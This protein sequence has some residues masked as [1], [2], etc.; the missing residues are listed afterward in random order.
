M[1][2]PLPTDANSPLFRFERTFRV[3]AADIDE[4]NHANNVVYV[5]WVQETAAAHWL[6]AIPEAEH[7]QYIWIVREHH[8]RYLRPAFEGDELRAYTWVGD[9]RGA[10]SQRFTRIE[11]VA[12]GVVLCEA[13]S[14]WVLLDPHTQ[15]PKRVEEAVMQRL[16]APLPK[17][18]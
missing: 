10:Q 4:L 17:H 1:P 15:R 7:D 11:R 16:R 3:E 14:Q 6:T 13:E 12:D 18:S 8:V 5:R 2:T 9:Y